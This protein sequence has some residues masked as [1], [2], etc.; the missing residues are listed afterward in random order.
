[1]DGR[2]IVEDLR[3]KLEEIPENNKPRFY[4]FRV[5]YFERKA[6]GLNDEKVGDGEVMLILPRHPDEG[7]PTSADSSRTWDD[8]TRHTTQPMSSKHWGAG[9]DLEAGEVDRL[10]GCCCECCH[11]SCCKVCCGIF[12]G[13]FPHHVTLNQFFTPTM[14][15][16]Y[17]RE[18]YR[19]CL[20]AELERFFSGTETGEDK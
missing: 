16:A 17:H 7:K 1:M 9:P 5:E 11:V 3:C 2:D 6:N 4:K 8:Y 18:G 19:A 20:D 10:N 13:M 12:C 14:F 15:S